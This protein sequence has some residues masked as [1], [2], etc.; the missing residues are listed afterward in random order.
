MNKFANMGAALVA[1][2]LAVGSVY[3]APADTEVLP[4]GA[5]ITAAPA[6][7]TLEVRKISDNT[8]VTDKKVDFGSVV[9]SAPAWGTVA[10]QYVKMSVDNPSGWELKT[11]TDNFTFTGTVP[12]KAIWGQQF[13]GLI[14]PAGSGKKVG[15]GW[16]VKN[17]ALPFASLTPG[18]PKDGRKLV[19]TPPVFAPGGNG[20]T[21]LKDK[22][23]QNLTDETGADVPGDQVFDMNSGYIN[24]AFGNIDETRIVAPEL[25]SGQVKLAAANSPMYLYVEGN[26]RG[27]SAAT[28][29]TVINYDLVNR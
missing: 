18:D 14:G 7:L 20:F 5:I 2:T 27:A 17:S 19:G 4:V 11:Y 25:E 1:V 29:S 6:D 16:T 21:Y 26:F 9:N 22:A 28:Y 13:G 8:L 12:D 10:P 23:D 24:I 3:A 15:M